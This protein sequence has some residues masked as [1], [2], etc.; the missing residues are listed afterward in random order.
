MNGCVRLREKNAPVFALLIIRTL[1]TVYLHYSQSLYF[2]DFAQQ[3]Y[4]THQNSSQRKLTN[5]VLWPGKFVLLPYMY[6]LY[7][8]YEVM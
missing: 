2:L 6:K 4:I 7:K 5:E 1:L 3:Y 8:Y